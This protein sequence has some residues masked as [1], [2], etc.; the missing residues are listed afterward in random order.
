MIPDVCLRFQIAQLEKEVK[1]RSKK[2]VQKEQQ[3][4]DMPIINPGFGG[5]LLLTQGQ[6]GSVGNGFPPQGPP[7]MANGTGMMPMMTGFP[8]GY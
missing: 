2:E 6:V 1:E 5:P 3:E 4:A 8:G 7:M